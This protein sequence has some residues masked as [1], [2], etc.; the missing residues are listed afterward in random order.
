MSVALEPKPNIGRRI[1]AVT[2]HLVFFGTVIY[3]ALLHEISAERRSISPAELRTVI[4]EYRE[5]KR[6]RMA[7]EVAEMR[8]QMAQMETIRDKRMA[9]AG[10]D[11]DTEQALEPFERES[12][13][14]AGRELEGLRLHSVYNVARSI[15]QNMVTLYRE[16]LAARLMG[17]QQ[18]FTYEEAYEASAT[19]RPTR[20]DLDVRALYRDISTT[21]PG[22]GLDEFKAEIK[23]STLEVR[24]MLEN[25]EK[26][27]AFTKKSTS[28]TGDGISVDM[29]AD[30]IAMIAYRG[31]ELLPDELDLT[32]EPDIGNFTAI[33]GRKLVTGGRTSE[34]MY[35]DSWYI[36]GPFPGDRRRENLD[37]RFGPEA[38][39]NLDDIFTGKDGL[40]IG[41]DYKKV[42]FV[43]Q[44]SGPKTAHWKIEPRRVVA[45][46]IYYAFTEIYSDVP[47]EVW[48]AT[49]TDDYGKLWINDELVWRSPKERKPYNAT[50]NIQL[51]NLAQGQNKILYRVENAGGTMGFSLLIRLAVD[52]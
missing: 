19:P 23:T 50:E 18:G 3:V 35:V 51:V 49:G 52:G 39:V 44:D 11:A 2:L 42:G 16:F 33:P 45:Y 13:A 47:R 48:I 12:R 28:E 10:V 27:L 40:K 30:D 26:L 17:L 20:P 36:I 37:V 8:A 41:W 6:V 14:M 21:E 46:A 1:V 5:K 34:W 43:R 9:E 38:N 22:G 7:S 29:S 25:C 31:P 32:H 4:A 15:E 24:E